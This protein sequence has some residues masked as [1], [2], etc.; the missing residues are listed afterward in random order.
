MQGGGVKRSWGKRR[1]KTTELDVLNLL[2]SKGGTECTDLP[3]HATGRGRGEEEEGRIK[4]EEALLCSLRLI[5]LTAVHCHFH[6]WPST[7]S[8]GVY[9]SPA[10]NE[11][12]AN[13]SLLPVQKETLHSLL[14]CSVHNVLSSAPHPCCTKTT[15]APPGRC[16]FTL[17]SNLKGRLLDHN[18]EA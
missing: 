18:R 4:E 3:A 10:P 8:A 13:P 9:P 6:S 11:Q 14:G 5:L 2:G 17:N 7:T 15:T 12:R 1:E 16:K